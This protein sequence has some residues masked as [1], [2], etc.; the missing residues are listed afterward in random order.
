MSISFDVYKD[1]KPKALT[2]SYDDGV[3]ADLKLLDVFNRHGVRGTFH[4]NA[5]YIGNKGRL[6]REQV[7]TAYAGHEIALHG[8]THQALSVTPR[9]R[10]ISE[11]MRDREVL[12]DITGAPVRGMSYAYGST[13]PDVETILRALGVAYCRRVQTT[14]AFTLP[15]DFLRW[16]G[17][18][19]HKNNLLHHADAFIS[20]P[21]GWR[22]PLMYVWGH[23]YE[24]DNDNNWDLIEEFCQRVSNNP[25]VWYA[26]NIEIVDY[27]TAQRSLQFT[28][29]QD[30]AHNPTALDVYISIDREPV[31]IPAGQTIRLV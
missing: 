24:F 18:C 28:A 21:R 17:T 27:I 8:Y 11:V 13:S 23:S 7:A 10:V 29:K 30:V 5:G 2:M 22:A 14:A 6:T 31:R 16:E 1:G 15:D 3:T 20:A 26:T 9:E 19:H 25:D 12:E 4:I